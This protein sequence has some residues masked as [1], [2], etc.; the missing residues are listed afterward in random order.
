VLYTLEQMKL[1]V[2]KADAARIEALAEARRRLE[3]ESEN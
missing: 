1:A 2:P 3:A